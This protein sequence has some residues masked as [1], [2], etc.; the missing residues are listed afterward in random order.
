[1][2]SKVPGS[3]FDSLLSASPTISN[4]RSTAD[5][6]RASDLY[7]SRPRPWTKSRKRTAA[8]R[9]SSRCFLFSSGIHEVPLVVHGFQ[10]E[11]ILLRHPPPRGLLSARRATEG[12]RAVRSRCL[13][14]LPPEGGGTR[15]GNPDHCVPR[16][17][18]HFCLRI[19]TPQGFAL[20]V[21]GTVAPMRLY[22]R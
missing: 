16:R 1:M 3:D 8:R 9:T 10:E 17:I 21:Q 12:S 14:A 5:R 13:L 2:L 18:P 11:R 20:R 7:P 15:R 4:C 19:R 6:R 22:A